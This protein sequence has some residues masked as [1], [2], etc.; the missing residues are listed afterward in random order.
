MRVTLC[1]CGFPV[2]AGCVRATVEGACWV[3]LCIFRCI[4]G[5]GCGYSVRVRVSVRVHSTGAGAIV[6]AI[7][8]VRVHCRG[9]WHGE[10]IAKS[11][12]YGHF[13]MHCI[14]Y[15]LSQR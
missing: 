8:G 5:C 7:V 6:R 4:N 10:S 15:L 3:R 1:A 2:R 9:A 12:V 13:I 11:R 14:M